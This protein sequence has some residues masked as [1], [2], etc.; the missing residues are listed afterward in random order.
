MEY[1]VADKL[2]KSVNVPLDPNL[3]VG[4]LYFICYCGFLNIKFKFVLGFLIFVNFS[5]Q[6][7]H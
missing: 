6:V 1:R 5:M 3:T 2:V 4:M 7:T